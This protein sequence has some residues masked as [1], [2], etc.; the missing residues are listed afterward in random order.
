MQKL[1]P[2]DPA[3]LDNVT[4]I[5]HGSARAWTVQ[6]GKGRELIWATSRAQAAAIVA[7]TGARIAGISPNYHAQ[8]MH[9]RPADWSEFIAMGGEQ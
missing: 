5:A 9:P 3:E 8:N 6:T 2:Y 1:Q 4:A 7:K